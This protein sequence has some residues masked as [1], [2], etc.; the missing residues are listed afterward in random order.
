M[1]LHVP[2]IVAFIV[3]KSM[4][5]VY[6]TSHKLPLIMTFNVQ[7]FHFDTQIFKNLPTVGGG[8]ATPS[9]AL[10]LRSLALAPRLQI[11]STPLL[12]A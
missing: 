3:Q 1:P 7:K 2:L 8:T 10:S 4:E 11:L 9:P 6:A 12:L 5:L